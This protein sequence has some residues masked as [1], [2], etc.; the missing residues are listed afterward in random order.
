M[1]HTGSFLNLDKKGGVRTG[2]IRKH[3]GCGPSVES[4]QH[5]RHRLTA[6]MWLLAATAGLHN[7]N[8]D[9]DTNISTAR[10]TAYDAQGNDVSYVKENYPDPDLFQSPIAV[11][12]V[13]IDNLGGVMGNSEERKIRWTRAAITKENRT[14]DLEVYNASEYRAANVNKVVD[15]GN[16]FQFNLRNLV[17]HMAAF[18]PFTPLPK[19]QA[20][21]RCIP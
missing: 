9:P 10:M 18:S 8:H 21:I 6:S 7:A 11:N 3:R 16:M 2:S 14:V 17:R 15:G 4:A 13:T 5:S 20:H 19:P 12:N 1:L